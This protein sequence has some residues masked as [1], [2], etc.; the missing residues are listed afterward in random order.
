VPGPIIQDPTPSWL[1][2]QN[3]SVFDAPVKKAIRSIVNANPVPDAMREWVPNP[4]PLAMIA[5][6]LSQLLALMGGMETPKG[7]KPPVQPSDYRGTHQAPRPS[8][9]APLHD[10]TGGGTIYPDDVYSARGP[11][12]YGTGY[13]NEDR[14]VFSLAQR[15]RGK[16]DATVTIYRA[17]PNDPAVTSIN[18]GDWVT[19]DPRYAKQHGESALD[20]DFKIIKTTAKASELFTNGDS[21]HEWGYHPRSETEK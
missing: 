12:Y 21:I 11:R 16:P 18:A 10:L 7:K 1:K 20:G 6:P 19:I 3:A 5:D 17:V 9:G 8:Y 14:A 4:N 2:P 15:L 13:P